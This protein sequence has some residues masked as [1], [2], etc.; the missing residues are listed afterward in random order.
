MDMDRGITAPLRSA[1]MVITTIILTHARRMATTVLTG[2]LEACSSAPV[3]GSEADFT[4]IADFM[5]ADSTD[6]DMAAAGFTDLVFTDAGTT[7]AAD[8][9]DEAAPV[10]TEV[11]SAEDS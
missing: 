5:V 10:L 2:S 1:R 3:R 9:S 11:A 6:V 4:G 7:A 8:L